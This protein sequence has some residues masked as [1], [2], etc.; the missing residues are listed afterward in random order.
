MEVMGWILVALLLC[1]VLA[2]LTFLKQSQNVASG[3]FLKL[4]FLAL[5][6]ALG[7]TMMFVCLSFSY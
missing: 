3:K 1:L 2:V 4:I 7:V 5:L 6:G